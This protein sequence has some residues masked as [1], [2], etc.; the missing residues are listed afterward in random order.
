MFIPISIFGSITLTLEN[1]DQQSES[2]PTSIPSNALCFREF[3]NPPFLDI[4]HHDVQRG[5]EIVITTDKDIS[6]TARS[7][8]NRC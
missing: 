2:L 7:N 6:L 4:N 8:I 1:K 5:L 3:S